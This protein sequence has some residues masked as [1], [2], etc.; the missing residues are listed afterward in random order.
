MFKSLNRDQDS[1]MPQSLRDFIGEDDLVFTIIEAVD[2]IDLTELIN[3]YHD[4]GQRAFYPRMMLALIFY[5]YSQGV[6][7]SRKIADKLKD[8]IRFMYLAGRQT[9]DFHTINSF[10]LKNMDLLKNYFIQ[11]VHICHDKGLTPLESVS[12]DGSKVHANASKKKDIAKDKLFEKYK[13]TEALIDQLLK[14]AMVADADLQKPPIP[15]PVVKEQLDELNKKHEVQKKA[16]DTVDNNPTQTVIN[17]AD[18]QCRYL[19]NTG[20]GY[21]VQIAVDNSSQVIVG[22]DVVSEANDKHQLLPMID[23]FEN[24]TDSKGLPKKVLADSGY[25]DGKAFQEL[26]DNYEHIDAYVPT[27]EQITRSKKKDGEFDKNDF[28]YDPVSK[29]CYCPAGI[30]M[31]F[32]SATHHTN[33]EPVIKFLGTGCTD[34]QFKPQCTKAEFRSHLVFIDRFQIV[35]NMENKLDS[36][37]GHQAMKLRRQSV[38]P[39]FGNLKEMIGFRRFM[40]RGLDKVKAEFAL[41]CCAHNLMKLH[42]YKLKCKA[43]AVIG[44][45]SSGIRNTLAILGNSCVY[46][47][48]FRQTNSFRKNIAE[49]SEKLWE[50]LN[51]DLAYDFDNR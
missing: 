34:C 11:I 22:I 44:K 33:K 18:P 3:R 31:R 27:R 45:T 2:I 38:E 42:R 26:A 4:L 13:E 14:S 47:I 1:F 40:L 49:F 48:K 20:P 6:F 41:L 24:T 29:E 5:A 35:K 7:S 30:K 25:A 51:R 39:V 36:P 15:H 8:S 37:A 19:K 32:L 28:Q 12:I 9:P 21:N 23:E 10:R 43:A 50:L 46:M 16:K 17:F